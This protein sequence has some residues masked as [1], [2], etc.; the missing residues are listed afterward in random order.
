MGIFM[1]IFSPV[2]FLSF[3]LISFFS[4]TSYFL[5][6][7]NDLFINHKVDSLNKSAV[8]K[9]IKHITHKVKKIQIKVFR[10]DKYIKS[11]SNIFTGYGYDIIISGLLY[12]HQPNI[13]S[14]QGNVG[15][16]NKKK[17]KRTAEF[18]VE[19]IK[20]NIIPPTISKKELDSLKV[21]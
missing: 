3:F 10:N 17:A 2:I 11:T 19:K 8:K 14:V 16:D 4:P 20:N 18:I 9:K 5:I 6:G 1:H 12:I 7:K 21:L 15:F 13:P